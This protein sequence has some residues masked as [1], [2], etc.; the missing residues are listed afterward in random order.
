LVSFRG[1]LAR[2]SERS[3]ATFAW[4]RRASSLRDGRH[5]LSIQ[6]STDHPFCSATLRRIFS[7]QPR[8]KEANLDPAATVLRFHF[9]NPVEPQC[10]YD[11]DVTTGALILRRTRRP[12]GLIGIAMF[13]ISSTRL[14]PTVSVFRSQS[15]TARTCAAPEVTRP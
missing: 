13:S 6:A 5:R 15:S 12:A 7:N 11:F 9:S 2:S 4:I 1:S 3:F 8:H 10:V 14:H